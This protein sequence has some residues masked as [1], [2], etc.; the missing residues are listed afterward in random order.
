MNILVRLNAAATDPRLTDL[1][2]R[3]LLVVASIFENKTNGGGAFAS[4]ITIAE[5]VNA[6]RRSVQNS[7]DRLVGCGYLRRDVHRGGFGGNRYY[8]AYAHPGAHMDAPYAHPGAHHMRTQVRT[9]K[10]YEPKEEESAAHARCDFFGQPLNGRSVHLQDITSER[11]ETLVKDEDLRRLEADFPALRNVRGR[12]KA[13]CREW[14][15]GIAVDQRMRALV[16]HLL[17]KEQETIERQERAATRI[18]AADAAA[19][20]RR[21]KA[22][23]NEA[24]R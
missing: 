5:L 16:G 24:W 6:C 13:A 11:G 12:V 21:E 10:K 8:L 4:Q 23:R 18:A 14:L 17:N 19:E 1:D 7:L 20:A 9:K 3:T 15:P 2:V 22:K